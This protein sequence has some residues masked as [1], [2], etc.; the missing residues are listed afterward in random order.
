MKKIL[1]FLL[2]I[3]VF[4]IN[5]YCSDKEADSLLLLPDE[6]IA[7]DKDFQKFLSDN[8][9]RLLDAYTPNIFMGYIPKELEKQLKKIYGA[10]I[11]RSRI[12]Y[13]GDFAPYGEKAMLA[14]NT[15]NKRLQEDPKMA[16]LVIDTSVK[17][18][19][20]KL[21]GLN[22]CWN[23]AMDAISYRLQTSQTET[24]DNIFFE[25]ITDRNCHVIMPAFWPDG[26]HYWRVAPALRTLNGEITEEP[27]SKPDSF[28]V[29]KPQN[30]ANKKVKKPTISDMTVTKKISWA[31]S[32][33]PFY[34]VQISDVNNF[35]MPIADV[36]S[37]TCT[38]KTADL[39]IKKGET[40]FLRIKASDGINQS[41][42][43]NTATVNYINVSKKANKFIK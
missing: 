26:V 2:V 28:A 39:P 10:K 4:L 17:K 20:R 9:A 12:E 18:I 21:S 22:L 24:F 16:P 43:S 37:D 3:G 32:D 7:Y 13:M 41:V 8:G 30:K 38:Y 23:K 25:V 19:G 34:R 14:A 42:W 35:S 1:I 15:W 33:Y 5:G 40:Y 6:N 27:F 31:P 36:F 11:Y 29:S